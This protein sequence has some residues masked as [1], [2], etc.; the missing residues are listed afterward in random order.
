MIRSTM[1]AM[2]AVVLVV[3]FA[4]TTA[5]G[6]FRAAIERDQWGTSTQEDGG[7]PLADIETNPWNG[8]ELD[9]IQPGTQ[10]WMNLTPAQRHEANVRRY[11]SP[12][13][14]AARERM[15]MTPDQRWEHGQAQA[16]Q[17]QSPQLQQWR[18][19]LNRR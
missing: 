8:A 1:L 10:A 5:A 9:Q 13:Q 6:D 15:Q 12:E 7:I 2:S 19:Q 3:G 4:R 16:R 11:M 17:H 14:K 18:E